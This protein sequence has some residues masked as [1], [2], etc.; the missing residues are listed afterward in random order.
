MA[1]AIEYALMAGRSYISTR[2]DVNLFPIPAGWAEFFHVP[3]STY[4]TIFGFEADSFRRGNEIVIAYA[5]TDPKDK[6]GNQRGQ[7]QLTF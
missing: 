7:H 1:T 5:G 2:A 6:F 3:N 4:P